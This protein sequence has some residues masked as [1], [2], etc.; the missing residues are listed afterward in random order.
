MNFDILKSKIKMAWTC[1]GQSNKDMVK[2][3]KD[4]RLI[5]NSLAISVMEEVD[6]KEFVLEESM[7][8]V[9]SPLS[10]G[11]DVTIS[12]PHMHAMMLDLIAPYAG[13]GKVALDIGSGSGYIVACMGKMFDMVYGI[14]HIEPLVRRSIEAVQKFLPKSKFEIVC[15]DGRLGYEKGAPYDVIHI[16]AAAKISDVMTVLKQ[17]KKTGMLIAP[18][19]EGAN[20]ALVKFTYNEEG[21]LNSEFICGVIFVPL[22][23]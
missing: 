10:I 6:R 23:D 13:P 2:K 15:G 12:A 11:Y 14:D 1:H 18:V 4:N 21:K 17:L 16:G 19:D 5:K 9:D 22:T 7:A 20:Q 3:L 8:Y